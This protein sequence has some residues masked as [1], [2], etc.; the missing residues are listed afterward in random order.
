MNCVWCEEPVLAGEQDPAFHAQAMHV[1]CGF[2]SMVG[3]VGHLL[4]R[5]HCFKL[6]SHLGDPP[7]LKK[8]DAACAALSLFRQMVAW[9]GE[10]FDA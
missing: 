10:G 1:E 6:N 7:G 9:Y 8:R 2:R 4:R 3:S 5:C